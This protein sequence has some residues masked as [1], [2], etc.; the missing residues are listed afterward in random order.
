MISWKDLSIFSKTLILA[1]FVSS[2]AVNVNAAESLFKRI[3]F[4][5]S[6]AY[7]E[8]KNLNITYP[9]VIVELVI[10]NN[11]EIIFAANMGEAE[12]IKKFLKTNYNLSAEIISINNSLLN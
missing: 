2:I 3:D 1:V 8:Y 5:E 7:L 9:A 10:S 11:N 12:A 4:I 6:S